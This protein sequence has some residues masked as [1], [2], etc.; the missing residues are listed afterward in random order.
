VSRPDE[1]LVAPAR[2]RGLGALFA[3][4][5]REVSHLFRLEL[6]LARAEITDQ[7]GQIGTGAALVAAGA[8]ILFAGVLVLLEAAVLALALVLAPWLAALIVGGLV[9]LLGAVLALKGR[10]DIAARSLMP[11]RTLRTLREDAEWAREQMR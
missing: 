3:D 5:S 11:S 6:A 4:L 1:P 8:L 2:D 7:A 10:H 9:L